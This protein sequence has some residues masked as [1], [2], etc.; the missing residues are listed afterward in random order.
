[1]ASST[2]IIPLIITGSLVELTSSFISSGDFLKTGLLLAAIIV[3]PQPSTSVPTAIAPPSS[4]ILK[5]F[6]RTSWSLGLLILTPH[7][8]PTLQ[9]AS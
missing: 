3:E 5:T 8:S 4:Y 2:D 6:F 9:M 7:P 1:M